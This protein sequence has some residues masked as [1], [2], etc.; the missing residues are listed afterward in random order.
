MC[1]CLCL[2][3]P[4]PVFP[5]PVGIQE[6][7]PRA[8]AFPLFPPRPD[9]H[10]RPRTH[11]PSWTHNTHT[12]D[13]ST[14]VFNISKFKKYWLKPLQLIQHPLHLLIDL[15]GR[16]AAGLLIFS[17]ASVALGHAQLVSVAALRRLSA[18]FPGPAAQG[19]GGRGHLL[20]RHVL[21]QREAL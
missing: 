11:T 4:L 7:P 21:T 12:L 16:R 9:C 2:Y 17:P 5:L 15:I 6:N 18:L 20:G 8:E 19:G 1:V 10:S 13:T 3:A 14:T